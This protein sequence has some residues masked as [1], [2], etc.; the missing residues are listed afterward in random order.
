MSDAASGMPRVLPFGESAWLVQLDD[1][2][3]EVV[4]ARVHALAAAIETERGGRLAG[5]GRPVPAYASLLVTFDQAAIDPEVAAVLLSELAV[6]TGPCHGPPTDSGR[7]VEIGVRYGGTDGPDL[8]AVARR[9]G[10]SSVRVIELHAG[11][12]YRVYMLGFAPGFAYLG[13]L[14]E[15]LELPR[16]NEPRIRVPAGSVAIAARQTAVYPF[17]T[18]GGWHLLGRTDFQSWDLTAEPPARLL[19]GD[20]VRFLPL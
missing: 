14:P 10:L 1:S 5:L 15:E 8:E 19:P 12:T 9:T 7:E 4:N 20:R 11:V 2:I 6:A 18:A 17:A 3:D 13:T 16:R